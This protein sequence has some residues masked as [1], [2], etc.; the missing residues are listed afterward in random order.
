MRYSG[1]TGM[2]EIFW[3]HKTLRDILDTLVWMWHSKYRLEVDWDI[4][5]TSLWYT[6][7]NEILGILQFWTTLLNIQ[8][9]RYGWSIV[10]ILI[11]KYKHWTTGMD[12]A[13]W[14]S[15]GIRLWITIYE[16]TCMEVS[17]LN[18]NYLRDL[19]NISTCL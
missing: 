2:N 9:Y 18:N 15:V 12:K 16:Y 7:V 11:W 19:C 8:M 6:Q 14:I 17:N 10:G 5:G 1:H 3:I 13:L 4:V